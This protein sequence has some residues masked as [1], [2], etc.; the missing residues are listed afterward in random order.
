MSGRRRFIRKLAF[1]PEEIQSLL[2]GAWIAFAAIRDA[3]TAEVVE[4]LNS[5]APSGT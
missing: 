1:L 2:G 4:N 3:L 5:A